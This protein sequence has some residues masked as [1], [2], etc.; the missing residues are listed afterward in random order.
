MDQKILLIVAAIAVVFFPQ[1]I[2]LVSLVKSKLSG[3]WSDIQNRPS[4]VTP[5]VD[6]NPADWVNDLFALQQT[7]SANDRKEA[8]DLV[9][10]A[11]VKLV[12]S[13]VTKNG[14]SRR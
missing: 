13:S 8:A 4:P 14:G 11:I 3:L 10:Q 12:S 5:T 2:N 7:L 6:T 1:V 9:G